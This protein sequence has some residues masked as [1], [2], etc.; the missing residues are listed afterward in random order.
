MRTRFPAAAT[1]AL[2]VSLGLAMP[3]AARTIVATTA[4]AGGTV[5]VRTGD[6][7]IVRLPGRWILASKTAP[8]LT[9]DTKTFKGH[10]ARGH[11]AITFS[12]ADRGMVHLGVKNAVTGYK[13]SMVIEVASAQ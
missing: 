1:A 13:L 10:G 2:I 9:L 3:A 12:A 5:F 7:L 8:E 4:D 11:T 6:T